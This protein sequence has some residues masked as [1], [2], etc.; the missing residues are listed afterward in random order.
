MRKSRPIGD[1]GRT[2][3]PYKEISSP[4]WVAPRTGGGRYAGSFDDASFTG[5]HYVTGKLWTQA[6]MASCPWHPTGGC[7]FCRHGTYERVTPAGCRVARWYCPEKG[8]T[9]S[10]L[11]DCLAARR[12]GTLVELEAR[13]LTVEHTRSLTRAAHTTRT[14]IELPG[15]LRYLSRLRTNIHAALAIVRRLDPERFL[16][17]VPTLTT[18][19]ALFGVANVLMMLC[20]E[21]PASLPAL[22]A[23]L[24]FD[25]RRNARDSTVDHHQHRVG[26]DPP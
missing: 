25:P 13:L 5:E 10:A 19:A 26:C 12:S 23:P 3:L 2:T 22:P 4:P 11:P 16:G 8:C 7:G 17:V 1:T 20:A 14:E 18:F 24:C 6:T 15:A 21:Y 9:V